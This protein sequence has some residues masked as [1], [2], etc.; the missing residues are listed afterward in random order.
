M[1]NMDGL[2]AGVSSISLFFF[3]VVMYQLGEQTFMILSMLALLGA[4]L[5]F[6]RHNFN[7][8]RIFMGDAGSMFIGYTLACLIVISTFYTS[9]SKTILAIAMPPLVLAVP[10]FD[11]L[12]V[13]AIRI[14]RGLPIYDA[15]KNHF[16]H[17]LV[18]L[19]MT[20]KSAVLFIYLV[21]FC[22]GLGA[23][24]LHR[25]DL[26]MGIVVLIQAAIILG[27]ILFLERTGKPEK[28]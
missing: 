2:C 4:I 28:S 14:K 19:G 9:Q 24:I 23:L 16:S 8:A 6:L 22:T 3:S 18:A 7:P 21:T 1:D 13:I 15:D 12:T 10:L 25:A 11:T 17:R 5:G 27:L 20:H 26:F